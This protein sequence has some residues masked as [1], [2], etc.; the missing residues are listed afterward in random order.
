[1]G[2]AI[3]PRQV[4]DGRARRG[5]GKRP[6]HA[7]TFRGA[8]G[9]AR[10]AVI[11]FFVLAGLS[12]SAWAVRIPDVKRALALD[13]ATLG[14]VLLGTAAGSVVAMSA[15]GWTIAR[16][17]SRRVTTVAGFLVCATLPLPPLAPTAAVL[18]GA[19]AL[20]GA[21]YGT[22]DVAMNAQAVHVEELAGRPIMSSFH[23]M[24]SSGALG[25]LVRGGC[26]RRPG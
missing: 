2:R 13:D 9:S 14:L 25:R 21:A 18:F 10:A 11:A 3:I 7:V 26:H 17:G 24:F 4:H 8:P 20:F 1:M 5:L 23:A 15:S 19:L 22:L 12:F 16:F 6:S